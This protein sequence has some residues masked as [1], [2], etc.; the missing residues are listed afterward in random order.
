MLPTSYP[1]V[2]WVCIRELFVI[3]QCYIKFQICCFMYNGTLIDQPWT[4]NQI[5]IQSSEPWVLLVQHQTLHS[6]SNSAMCCCRR[7]TLKQ[8]PI[9]KSTNWALSAVSFPSIYWNFFTWTCS[10]G[11]ILELLSSKII[12]KTQ[13]IQKFLL[14]DVCQALIFTSTLYFCMKCESPSIDLHQRFQ[15]G[16]LPLL[17]TADKPHG[18][19]TI[20]LEKH[21]QHQNCTDPIV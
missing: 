5:T 20:A 18:Q 16:L 7:S 9:N 17:N 8:N 4:N 12:I 19:S 6:T 13:E 1:S 14:K 21:K 15:L 10:P 11:L 2:T 3:L